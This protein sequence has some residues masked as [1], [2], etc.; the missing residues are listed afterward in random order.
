MEHINNK[1][2]STRNTI[3]IGWQCTNCLPLH[4]IAWVM[5]NKWGHHIYFTAAQLACFFLCV[6]IVLQEMP[7]YVGFFVCLCAYVGEIW[8]QGRERSWLTWMAC[9][10]LCISILSPSK[11]NILIWWAMARPWHFREARWSSTARQFRKKTLNWV[12]D[13]KYRRL[14]PHPNRTICKKFHA[15]SGPLWV[16]CIWENDYFLTF[17]TAVTGDAAWQISPIIKDS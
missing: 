4:W 13:V 10:L 14:S 15:S 11:D 1:N 3:L 12:L 6:Q 9:C 16:V 2:V 17:H 5:K 7:V 8:K